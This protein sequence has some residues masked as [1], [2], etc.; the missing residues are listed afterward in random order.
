MEKKLEEETDL[1]GNID[2]KFAAHYAAIEMQLKS[3]TVGLVTLDEMKARQEDA[4]KERM[5]EMARKE[6]AHKDQLKK[7]KEEK[8]LAKEKRK[9]EIAGLS[10][11]PFGDEEEEAAAAAA[12]EEEVEGMRWPRP[13]R[14]RRMRSK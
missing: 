6:Q 4:V 13:R 8:R 1:R 12:A 2:K 9:K 5:Q 3:E 7:E 10:F 11:D 14:R